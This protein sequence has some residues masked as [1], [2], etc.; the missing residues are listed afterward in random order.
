MEEGISCTKL[1]MQVG[2][3]WA[4]AASAMMEGEGDEGMAEGRLMATKQGNG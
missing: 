3:P 2:T 1:D 4:G